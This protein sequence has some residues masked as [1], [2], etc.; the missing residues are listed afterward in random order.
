MCNFPDAVQEKAIFQ[1]VLISKT[2]RQNHCERTINENTITYNPRVKVV[3]GSLTLHMTTL[4]LDKDEIF[5][6]YSRALA[7]T[8]NSAT[9]V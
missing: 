6:I 3:F 4:L 2:Y 5:H 9:K 7:Y 1:Q 8:K